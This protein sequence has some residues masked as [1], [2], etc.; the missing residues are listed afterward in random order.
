M[1][2]GR[3]GNRVSFK[4]TVDLPPVCSVEELKAFIEDAIVVHNHDFRFGINNKTVQVQWPNRGG[5]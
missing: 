2:R 5:S 3:Y 1:R 4:V